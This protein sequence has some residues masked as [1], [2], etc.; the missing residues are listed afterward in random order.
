MIKNY[1]L[2]NIAF[3]LIL[4]MLSGCSAFKPIEFGEIRK[5]KALNMD[6]DDL[7]MELLIEVDNPNFFSVEVINFEFKVWLND[8][9]IGRVKPLVKFKVKPYTKGVIDVPVQAKFEGNIFEGFVMMMK[10]FEQNETQYRAE[11]DVSVKALLF[12]RTVRV[13]KTGV[14]KVTK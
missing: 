10:V 3:V 13:E 6:L 14:A 8:F 5:V 2:H 9:Y 4:L 12:T 7:R 1:G 11:G